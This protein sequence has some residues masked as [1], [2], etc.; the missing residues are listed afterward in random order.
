MART[1]NIDIRE[2][3]QRNYIINGGFDFWQRGTSASQNGLSAGQEY[4]AD[5]FIYNSDYGTSL[6]VTRETDHPENGLYSIKYARV[7]GLTGA[8]PNDFIN[9]VG[10]HIEGHNMANLV[11][12]AITVSFW[13]KVSKAGIYCISLRN[14][15][16]GRSYIKEYTVNQADTWE[17]KSFTVAIENSTYNLETGV[18]ISLRFT[19]AAGSNFHGTEGEWQSGDLHATANQTQLHFADT[20]DYFQFTQVQITEGSE[21]LSF[22]RAGKTVGE[23]LGFCQRYYLRL[24]DGADFGPV[25]SGY[26]RNG[27]TMFGIIDFPVEMRIT[28]TLETSS[29][30]A[31]QLQYSNTGADTTAI[32]LGSTSSR[33]TNLVGSI[34]GTPMSTGQAGNMLTR[35]NEYVAFDAEL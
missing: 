32:S 20:N 29:A 12:K 6:D 28:P 21:A 31:M 4:L 11:E 2:D 8:V 13:V 15:T 27:S 19:M 26:I 23:E 16:G 30:A 14:P 25:A 7:T 5:R 24:D 33:G 17:K 22:R 18:G 10:Q 1:P 35:P 34:A 3:Y 9:F